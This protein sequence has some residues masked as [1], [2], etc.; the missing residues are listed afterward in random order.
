MRLWGRTCPIT[1]AYR[2]EGRLRRETGEER[3]FRRKT[4]VFL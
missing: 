3:R 2:G 4:L 1:R